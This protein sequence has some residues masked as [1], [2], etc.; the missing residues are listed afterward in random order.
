VVHQTIATAISHADR[1]EKA[2]VPVHF[3]AVR[4]GNAPGGRDSRLDLERFDLLGFRTI[5]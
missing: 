5:F 1:L 3:S 2:D 4:L